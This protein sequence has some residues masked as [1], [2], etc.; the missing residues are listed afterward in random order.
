MIA[1]ADARRLPMADGSVQTCIT[2]PPYERE[3]SDGLVQETLFQGE[4]V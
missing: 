1:N 3:A 4:N 2:S